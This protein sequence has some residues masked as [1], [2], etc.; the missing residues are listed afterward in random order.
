MFALIIQSNGP[1][2]IVASSENNSVAAYVYIVLAVNIV[3]N[4]I[5]YKV[6]APY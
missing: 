1:F 6:M 3:P 4:Y 5:K 2:K